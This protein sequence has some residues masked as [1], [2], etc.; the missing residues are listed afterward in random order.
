MI[1]QIE[2]Y[3][4]LFCIV[5]LLS[6]SVHGQVKPEH[7]LV[8]EQLSE[9]W[10][11]A[12]PLGNGIMGALIWEKDGK[13]RLGLDRA[14]LWDLRSTPEF[15]SPNFNFNFIYDQVV[16]KK[17]IGPVSQ[18]IDNPYS[19]NAGPTK[20]PAGAIEFNIDKLGKVKQVSLSLDSA[21]AQSYGKMVLK[22]KCLSM[23]KS[24]LVELDLKT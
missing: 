4:L 19:Y 17:D 23:L 14:D 7:N 24:L 3:L 12:M 13:L 6:T 22:H 18:M 2:K 10:D 1:R 8:F 15:E 5:A 11:E 9:S 21:T 20:I 16:N